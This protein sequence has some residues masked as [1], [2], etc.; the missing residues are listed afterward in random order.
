LLTFTVNITDDDYK[1][2]SSQQDKDGFVV[3]IVVS[4]TCNHFLGQRFEQAG[5]LTTL[6]TNAKTD[7]ML[8]LASLSR[9]PEPKRRTHTNQQVLGQN[10]N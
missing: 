3:L 9:F 8:L 7:R 6:Y 4:H 2:L 10:V 5:G 1:E